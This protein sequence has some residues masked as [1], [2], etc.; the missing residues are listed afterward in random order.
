MIVPHMPLK[1]YKTQKARFELISAL[2]KPNTEL[3]KPV[4]W[5]NLKKAW[6]EDRIYL[7]KRLPYKVIDPHNLTIK[8]T[9]GSTY[10]LTLC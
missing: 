5:H 7:L 2:S 10:K 1:C 4:A 9:N 3:I 8:F 6:K